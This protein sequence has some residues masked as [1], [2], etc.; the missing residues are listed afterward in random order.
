MRD[1]RAQDE[2]AEHHCPNVSVWVQGPDAKDP[3]VRVGI[4]FETHVVNLQLGR[5]QGEQCENDEENLI[6]RFFECSD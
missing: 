2:E 1:G 6:A 4:L 3:P 5:K